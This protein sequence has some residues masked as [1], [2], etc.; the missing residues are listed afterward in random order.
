MKILVTGFEPFGGSRINPSEQVICKLPGYSIPG[1]EIVTGLLP[2]DRDRGPAQ[3]ITL[4]QE[5]A[6]QAVL[7]LGEA[8]RRPV[9]SIERVGVNLMDY[10]I[11]DNAG[12]KIIDELIDP[13][14][15]AAYFATLPVRSIYEALLAAQIPVEMSMSA[16]AYLCNQVLYTLL[17]YVSKNRLDVPAGFIHLPVL[18]EQACLSSVPVPSMSLETSLQGTMVALHVI[19]ESI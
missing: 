14:G 13:Q 9:I 16:G 15:P 8:S 6:P 7:C 17:H 18:P 12:Q 4:L 3:L 11:P 19:A 5:H 1:I 2:V 10:R